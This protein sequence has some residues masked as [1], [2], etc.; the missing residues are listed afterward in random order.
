MEKKFG[1]NPRRNFYTEITL[2]VLLAICS[3]F[4]KI[5][6]PKSGEIYFP[7]NVKTVFHSPYILYF[8]I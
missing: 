5:K 2:K 8:L 1:D 6:V 4:S 7:I 3:T